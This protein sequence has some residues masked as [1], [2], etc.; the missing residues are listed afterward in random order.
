MTDESNRLETTLSLEEQL[1][2]TLRMIDE[3]ELTVK[4]KDTR[5]AQL[6]SEVEEA[7]VDPVTG[8]GSLQGFLKTSRQML[9]PLSYGRETTLK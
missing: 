6:E 7:G 1:E 2:M 5:I 8:A 9:Y 4:E 3:L